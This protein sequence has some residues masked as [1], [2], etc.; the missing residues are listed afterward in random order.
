MANVL[1]QTYGRFLC[2]WWFGDKRAAAAAI[3]GSET[4][5]GGRS[6]DEQDEFFVSG[7]KSRMQ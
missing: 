3:G 7:K 5:K 6:L 4:Q 1:S 2:R